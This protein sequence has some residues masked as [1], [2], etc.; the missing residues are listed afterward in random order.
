M[1]TKFSAKVIAV[2]SILP[3]PNWRRE[4]ATT[5]GL[6]T[7]EEWYGKDNPEDLIRVRPVVE[8][9]PDFQADVQQFYNIAGHQRLARWIELE[10]TSILARVYTELTPAEELAILQDKPSLGLKKAEIFKSLWLL[11][12][13]VKTLEAW[14]AAIR[15]IGVGNITLLAAPKSGKLEMS[16][17]ETKQ[18][19]SYRGNG[20][21]WSKTECTLRVYLRTRW[22]GMKQS[23]DALAGVRADVAEY[24][25]YGLHSRQKKFLEKLP[26]CAVVSG[27]SDKGIFSFTTD[28]HNPELLK[29]VSMGFDDYVKDVDEP[30]YTCPAKPVDVVLE[31]KADTG[32]VL[33]YCEQIES[34]SLIEYLTNE[35]LLDD[36]LFNL[37]STVDGR[38]MLDEYLEAMSPTPTVT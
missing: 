20:K 26:A 10:N 14:L 31:G 23:I 27:Y 29:M 19:V 15:Q 1:S 6:L 3:N 28:F 17:L 35:K 13:G 5:A 18:F 12:A 33:D 25:G 7:I 32:E 16:A 30:L 37:A 34:G 9:D 21:G 38:A 11:L 4:H 8:G 2:S 24:F 36:V 22:T